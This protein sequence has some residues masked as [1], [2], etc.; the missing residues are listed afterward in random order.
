MSPKAPSGWLLTWFLLGVIVGL[1]GLL[2]MVV[3]KRYL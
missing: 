2:T 1:L 3:A